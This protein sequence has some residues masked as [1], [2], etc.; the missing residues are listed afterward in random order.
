MIAGRPAKILL[1]DSN[2]YFAKRLGDALKKE[3]FEVLS[4]TQ[5]AFALTTLE[6]D[7]PAAIVCATNMREMGALEIAKIIHADPKNATLPIIALGDGSQRALMEAFQAG[8]EDYIDRQRPPA[9]IATHIRQIVVSKAE[10]FQP[11]QMLAQAD[12]SLSGNLT[13]HDLPGVLQ[14]LGHAHQTGA[15]HINAGATDALLFFDAGIITHAEC[16]NLFGDEAVIHIIKSCVHGDKG[17]YKFVYGA[18]SL[19]HTVLRNATDL[20]LDAMREYDESSHEHGEPSF[21]LNAAPVAFDSPAPAEPQISESATDPMPSGDPSS[22]STETQPPF[23]DE[24]VAIT[25][26]DEQ[27]PFATLHSEDANLDDVS[28]LANNLDFSHVIGD[29]PF[30]LQSPFEGEIPAELVAQELST[31]PE[32]RA[33]ATHPWTV[34]DATALPQDH[35]SAS[36]TEDAEPAAAIRTI[37]KRADLLQAELSTHPTTIT[38]RI[39]SDL[40]AHGDNPVDR[41][42]A[43]LLCKQ[44]NGEYRHGPSDS[45]DPAHEHSASGST[46]DTQHDH[47]RLSDDSENND[48]ELP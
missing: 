2:V 20:M 37:I 5:P 14:M 21:D 16:G 17:V 9:V 41:A 13:H 47:V 4:S 23:S 8:C 33:L 40:H 3:G 34:L 48:K 31:A 32:S 18:T 35:D 11:T 38:D 30:D 25:H 45:D 24:T 15:L 42:L 22:L 29:S 39:L 36:P 44:L 6:Y 1:I 7:A 46:E 28:K 27:A 10:G 19:K 43:E 26:A 12:T